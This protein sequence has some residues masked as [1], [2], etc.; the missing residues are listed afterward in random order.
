[1]AAEL[2]DVA[3]R[4]NAMRLKPDRKLLVGAATGRQGQQCHPSPRPTRA[5]RPS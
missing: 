5:L 2:D 4:R 3:G 1:M